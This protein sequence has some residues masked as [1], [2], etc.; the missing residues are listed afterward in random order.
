MKIDIKPAVQAQIDE[1]SEVV[2]S[3]WKAAYKE[4]ISA[5]D[6]SVFADVERRKERFHEA[7][8]KR[9]VIFCIICDGK[10]CGVIS[11]D[12]TKYDGV[13]MIVQLYILPEYQGKGF[14]R[15][16]LCHLLRFMR[17]SG[18]KEAILWVLE[19]NKSAIGFYE[20]IGFRYDNK[21]EKLENFVG[22]NYEL[23][24]RIEL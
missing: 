24:Y 20:K 13:C 11:A 14:G 21:R 2:T 1:M 8:E 18:Y 22:E 15:K 7:F 10:I 19:N 3:T 9:T 23:R 16:L 5:E 6:M 17:K 4:L 12:R